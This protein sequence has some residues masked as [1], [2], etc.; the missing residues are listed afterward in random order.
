MV[1][2]CAVATGLLAIAGCSPSPK[3]TAETKSAPVF[4]LKITQ[5]YSEPSVIRGGSEKAK[6]C[7]GVEGAKTVTL[8]PP[9]DRLWPAAV[10]CVEVSPRESTTYT[11][12][13]E[14]ERGTKVSAKAMVQV[15]PP[16]AKIVEV[17][18]NALEIKAGE[19][20]PFCVAA[21]NVK[22]W[23]LSTGQWRTPPGS[24]GGCVVDY[25]KVTTTY[26]ITA[27]GAL[28]ETDTE[29]VTAT[30]KP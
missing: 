26:V 24:K 4:P 22:S 20:F 21:I 25:P 19:A 12:T 10:R 11:L 2:V 18:V 6:L 5:F 15:G 1:R 13:A 23:K 30:V 9:V 14:D 3:G 16:A 29:R 27:V 28:G 17:S 8:D 7:Y